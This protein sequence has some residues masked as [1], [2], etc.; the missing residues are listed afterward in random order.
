MEK[1]GCALVSL[2][3]MSMARV[4]AKQPLAKLSKIARRKLSNLEAV[5][6][7]LF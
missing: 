7:V 5:E 1:L 2:F 6:S 4:Q 3:T